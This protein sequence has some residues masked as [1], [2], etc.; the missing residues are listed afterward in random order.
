[1]SFRRLLA[2]LAANLS[3]HSSRL[4][5][6]A[7]EYSGISGPFDIRPITNKPINSADADKPARRG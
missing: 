6:S 5:E 1:M 4:C 3:P 7:P 2:T